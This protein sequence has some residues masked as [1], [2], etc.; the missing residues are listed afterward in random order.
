MNRF[1]KVGAHGHALFLSVCRPVEF[2]MVV[3]EYGICL[4]SCNL[5]GHVLWKRSHVVILQHSVSSLSLRYV[6]VEGF[7]INCN[8]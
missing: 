4:V 1:A 6:C 5:L 3:F 2:E 7:H 8:Q